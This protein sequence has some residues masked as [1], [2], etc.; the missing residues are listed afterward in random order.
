MVTYEDA[1]AGTCP[2]VITRTYTVTDECGNE[3]TASYSIS[4][5]DTTPPEITGGI[6]D[7]T[8]EGCDVTAATV[9]A[10]ATTVAQLEALG[11][12]IADICTADADLVV[13]YEDAVAGTCP[14]VITRTYTV[15]DECGN[16]STASY[17]I[18]VDDTTPPEITG[19]ITDI[20]VEG[21]DVTAATV[22][23]PATTVAQLE[24]LGLTIADICTADA[25]LVVT[26][27]DAVAG[28]CP[29]VIT[30]TYT[31]TD[32][33][34]NESTASYSI[35][36]DDT[37]PPEITGGITDITVEGCDVTAATVPA[38]ATTVA[39][40][41]ALGL[42][43]ADICT[44]D[45]DLVVTYEDA[46]AGTCP[47]VITRTYTV[48]DEC[49]N[50]STA[51][52]SISVDDT[53]PPEITG[54]ITDITVEG[55]DVTAATVPAPATTVAQLEALGL[56]IADICTADAD[57]VV[58]YEDAVAGTCPIVI[59]RTYTVTDECGNES[60]ASYSISVDDTT[61]P[62]ITG[63]ITDITVEGCDVTAATV[64]APATTVAQLE[65][66]VLQ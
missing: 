57:L 38:P 33:C 22:P 4:V 63:G 49:G 3:S 21:C 29:I 47:I 54:G 52:Y 42:T 19:G 64:P 55:C 31:V 30:R 24:A 37:T 5:D 11:L 61:P 6:T 14:I 32:E 43:I 51:S 23:A 35:S 18:S 7:I 15:T 17:S 56:T 46:V 62:E 48:T 65:L 44:A 1:V 58:T 2:I 9:P 25:D 66:S 13:T 39:Q 60:T 28:T 20:T 8:V 50:E 27:E 26:Y 45:A 12:T 36:V 16:E 40:L 53:T 34:G 10:P 59:T 41:E